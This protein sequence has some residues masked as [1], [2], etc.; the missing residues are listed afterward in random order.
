[1]FRSLI[2]GL[3]YIESAGRGDRM[4]NNGIG[5]WTRTFNYYLSKN[6]V[7]S[8]RNSRTLAKHDKQDER[9]CVGRIEITPRYVMNSIHAEV[10]G[11][12]NKEKLWLLGQHF[13]FSRK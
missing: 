12:I 6:E 1:M 3:Q 9:V 11:K 4:T 7:W 13:E 5:S 8:G 2:Y 10:I